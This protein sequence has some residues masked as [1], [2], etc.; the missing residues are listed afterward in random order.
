M[1]EATG[2][3]AARMVLVIVGWLFV[4]AGLVSAIGERLDGNDAFAGFD[5]CGIVV[6]AV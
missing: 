2:N 6:G 1:A 5:A 3:R 4:A